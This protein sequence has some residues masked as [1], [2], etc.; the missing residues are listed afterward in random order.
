[1][2][3]NHESRRD[4]ERLGSEA[5][6]QP[7]STVASQAKKKGPVMKKGDWLEAVDPNSG[8]TYWH[9]EKTGESS[10]TDPHKEAGA[11]GDW[12]E[13]TDPA[14]GKKY[15]HNAKTGESS[16]TDPALK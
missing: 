13:A 12:T 15:W 10:W 5:A 4:L 2:M 1:M 3:K 14:S 7:A 6:G 9:N 11:G 8:R 16:W